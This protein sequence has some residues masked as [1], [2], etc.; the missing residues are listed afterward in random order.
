[1]QAPQ[2]GNFLKGK[3]EFPGGKIE[4]GETPEVAASRE[5][6]EEAGL[7]IEPERFKLFNIYDVHGE[8]SQVR[9]YA[10]IAEFTQGD[11]ENWYQIKTDDPLY[12]IE[13]LIMPANHQI[14]RDITKYL[15]LIAKLPFMA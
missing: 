11:E 5:C 2:E 14:I 13:D 12:K 7:S 4:A 6:H 1:M 10:M 3:L 8:N 15:T 9:L